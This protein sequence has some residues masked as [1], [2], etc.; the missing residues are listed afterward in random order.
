M[1]M[2]NHCKVRQVEKVDAFDLQSNPEKGERCDICNQA[3][4]I[5]FTS[6]DDSRQSIKTCNNV[7][8]LYQA[9][10]MERSRKAPRVSMLQMLNRRLS[11]LVGIH[12]AEG[13]EGA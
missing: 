8:V 5:I 13:G 6:I 1:K 7:D 4:W 11:K 10:I 3:A 9:S 2:C 12:H